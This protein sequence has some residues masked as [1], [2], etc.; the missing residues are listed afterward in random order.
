MKLWSRCRHDFSVSKFERVASTS[1]LC[2]RQWID[3]FLRRRPGSPLLL[4]CCAACQALFETVA[5]LLQ[6]FLDLPG[7]DRAPVVLVL[8]EWLN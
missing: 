3:N 6:N 7:K 5:T 2:R 4:K 1:N 8:L